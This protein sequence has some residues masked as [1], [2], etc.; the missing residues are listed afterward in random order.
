MVVFHKSEKRL[1]VINKFL[2]IVG[3]FYENPQAKGR[4]TNTALGIYV[5]QYGNQFL[6]NL[7]FYP[8]KSNFT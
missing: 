8:Y 3:K 7:T 5:M 4:E 2:T 6:K 1:L